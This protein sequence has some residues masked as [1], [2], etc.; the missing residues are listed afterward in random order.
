MKAWDN[1]FYVSLKKVFK[2]RPSASCCWEKLTNDFFLPNGYQEKS[3]WPPLV[4]LSAKE[5]WTSAFLSQNVSTALTLYS[6]WFVEAEEEGE[7]RLVMKD[8]F[9]YFPSR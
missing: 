8:D 4:A 3:A 6:S 9:Y 2:N 5:T 1:E 7:W